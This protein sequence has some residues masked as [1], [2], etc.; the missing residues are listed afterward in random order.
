MSLILDALS[1]AE[2]EKA[3]SAVKPAP[4]A[5]LS[6]IEQAQL[7]AASAQVQ[8]VPAPP[9]TSAPTLRVPRWVLTAL[10][11]V[12]VALTAALLFYELEL[13]PEA[14][15]SPASRV[16]DTAPVEPLERRRQPSG[17]ALRNS[18]AAPDD[19]SAVRPATVAPPGRNPIAATAPGAVDALY[20]RDRETAAV[21]S[22]K[23]GADT[24]DSDPGVPMPENDT[25]GRESAVRTPEVEPADPLMIGE[26]PIDLEKVLRQVRA[27]AA[28]AALS[29]HPIVL[30]GQKSKQFRDAVPTLM[31]LRHDFNPAGVSTVLINSEELREGQATRGVTVRSILAD[32]VILS[33]NGTEFRLRAL[34]SWVNL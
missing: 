17:E 12:V 6:L 10:A 2:R 13:R 5:D 24:P 33:Y 1:R 14:S 7:R 19:T 21:V 18:V 28:A 23:A 4:P 11:A 9:T 16:A 30:L 3:R 29:P 34:N 27:E 22:P 32:S 20:A 15:H 25:A 31:Y 26:E 8:G